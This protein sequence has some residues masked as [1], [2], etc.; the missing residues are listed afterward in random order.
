MGCAILIFSRSCYRSLLNINNGLPA[1]LTSSAGI[2]L[3]PTS[4]PF[5]VLLLQSHF[6]TI[7]S[8][9]EPFFWWGGGGDG[10]E[11]GGADFNPE[12]RCHYNSSGIVPAV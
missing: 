11:G 7:K 8:V 5:L 3:N 9:V 1:S 6:L 10:V 4:F 12:L 2:L